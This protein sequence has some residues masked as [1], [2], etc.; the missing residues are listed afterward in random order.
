MS[1]NLTDYFIYA[2][3]SV[4]CMV[5]GGSFTKNRSIIMIDLFLNYLFVAFTSFVS[6]AMVGTLTHNDTMAWSTMVTIAII[7]IAI[8]HTFVE[9]YHLKAEVI[10]WTWKVK[11]FNWEWDDAWGVQPLIIHIF[12]KTR[13]GKKKLEIIWDRDEKG[14]MPACMGYGYKMHVMVP[15][16]ARKVLGKWWTDEKDVRRC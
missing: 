16:L 10:R 3:I 5:W 13:C 14:R 7:G 4:P 6:G 1:K 12:V 2:M 15:L 11:P 8:I 9:R